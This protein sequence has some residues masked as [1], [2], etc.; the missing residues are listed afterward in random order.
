MFYVVNLCQLGDAVIKESTCLW[1]GQQCLGITAGN[2]VIE[3][4]RFVCFTCLFSGTCCLTFAGI[5]QFHA[6]SILL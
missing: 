6:V 3:W 2:K 5:L 1:F 4:I